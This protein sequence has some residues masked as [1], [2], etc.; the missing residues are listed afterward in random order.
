MKIS[1][2]YSKLRYRTFLCTIC[3]GLTVSSAYSAT[4]TTN[5][6]GNL[7]G[8]QTYDRPTQVNGVPPW[9]ASGNTYNYFSETFTPGGSGNFDIEVLGSSTLNDP[10]LYLYVGSFDPANPTVN[11]VIANDDGGAGLLSLISGQALVGGTQY[12]IVATSFGTGDTGV[13]DFQ[14][15][16]PFGAAI[17]SASTNYVDT[18]TTVGLGG[19]ARYFDDNDGSGERQ[20]VAVH[21]DSLSSGQLESALKTL[22]PHSSTVTTGVAASVNDKVTVTLL[23]KIGTVLGSSTST[24]QALSF[25]D[26]S[27]N[28]GNWI[29]EHKESD[30]AVSQDTSYSLASSSYE[31]FT[32]GDQ[33]AWGEVIVSRTDGDSTDNA[34]GYTGTGRGLVT[35]YEAVL[36]DDLLVGVLGGFYRAETELDDNAGET[37]ANIYNLGIYGQKLYDGIKLSGVALYG[38][39]D[40]DSNRNVD[41]AGVKQ[42]PQAD[43]DSHSLS[44][45]LGLS[46]LYQHGDYNIEPFVT[47]SGTVIRVSGYT[48]SGGGEFNMS[49]EDDTVSFVGAKAGVTFQKNWN[50]KDETALNFKL[51]PYVG[52]D[53]EIDS[54]GSSVSFVNSTGSTMIEGRDLSVFQAGL[55]GEVAYDLSSAT[56]F[57]AGFDVSHKEDEDQYVGFLGLGVKF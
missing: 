19:F 41:L 50:F 11:G 5:F 9:T 56:S 1:R 16:G 27:A 20:T 31:S 34:L 18:A 47:A 23:D 8:S 37:V 30:T 14:L 24:V 28:L 10:V 15:R 44:G 43:F 35:G 36:S 51:K 25:G 48:E 53:W 32:P 26:G 29:F 33:G 57:K 42:T 21:L 55:S 12:F 4:I 54:A 46:K 2:A 40:Y 52:H 3:Y 22:Y 38:Y 7:D 17:G 13:F 49:V 45:T 6:S 39:G